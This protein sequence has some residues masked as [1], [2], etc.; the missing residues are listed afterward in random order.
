MDIPLKFYV[1]VDPETHVVRLTRG[2][3]LGEYSNR[4]DALRAARMRGWKLSE[5]GVSRHPEPPTE[6]KTAG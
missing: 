1:V 6:S 5:P 4:E 2:F 3:A